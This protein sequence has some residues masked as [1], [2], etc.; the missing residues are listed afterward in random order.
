MFLT[1]IKSCSKAM[2]SKTNYKKLKGTQSAWNKFLRLA[3]NAAAPV[4]GMAIG[5]EAASANLNHA[6][7]Y[8]L[9]LITG[10]KWRAQHTCRAMD[11]D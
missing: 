2:G 1:E 8:I 7:S 10:V 3:L 6:T 11:W 9:R 4:I 5:A